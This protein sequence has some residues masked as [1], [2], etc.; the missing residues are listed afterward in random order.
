[1]YLGPKVLPNGGFLHHLDD[2]RVIV[3]LTGS[4]YCYPDPLVMDFVSP[5]FSTC[6]NPCYIMQYHYGVIDFTSTSSLSTS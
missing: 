4:T 2:T 1:M 6:I 5:Y 3:S